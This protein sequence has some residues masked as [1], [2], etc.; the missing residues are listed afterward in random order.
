MSADLSTITA[1]RIIPVV[2]LNSADRADGLAQ[3]LV[4]GGLPV[5]EVTFRTDAAV[6]SIEIMARHGDVLVG[7]GTVLDVGQVH[8]ALDAG[9]GF[10]VSPG[11]SQA[12]V[13]ECLGLGV[14]VL[15]GTATPTDVTAAV[16]SGL[17]TVKFFPAD[18]LG[19]AAT[20]K[21]LS[22]PFP[23]VRFIPT[24]GVNAATVGEYLA[25]DCVPAVGGS[26]MVPAGL[27]DAGEF[28][29]VTE[30]VAGAVDAVKAC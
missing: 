6:E 28:N 4:D 30:L 13:D 24:G 23:Q 10:I 2:V 22:G 12:V 9:A 3:A 1:H 29:R 25:L 27:I 21:A 19:G 20:I 5:A 7:A 11:Y 15:P 8:R 16:N 14:P 17:D 18:P 26:W